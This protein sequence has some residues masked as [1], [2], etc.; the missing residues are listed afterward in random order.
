MSTVAT[1]VGRA[2]QVWGDGE[3]VRFGPKMG[4]PADEAEEFSNLLENAAAVASAD[5]EHCLV[6]G[7]AGAVWVVRWPC[8]ITVHDRLGAKEHGGFTVQLEQARDL[9]RAVRAAVQ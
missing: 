9:G 3:W 6:A 8:H 1:I 5:V 4:V 7:R 2:V